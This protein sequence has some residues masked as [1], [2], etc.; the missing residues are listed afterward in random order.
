MHY[1]NKNEII[2]NQHTREILITGTTKNLNSHINITVTK[3]QLIKL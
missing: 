3:T 1:P 2:S